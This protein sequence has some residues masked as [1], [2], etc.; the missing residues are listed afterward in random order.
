MKYSLLMTRANGDRLFAYG[1]F[2]ALFGGVM[3]IKVTVLCDETAA[4]WM[5]GWSCFMAVVVLAGAWL[6][7]KPKSSAPAPN[8]PK[9]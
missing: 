5:I 8:P 1:S 2:V 3:A 4:L 6:T 7:R 9:P